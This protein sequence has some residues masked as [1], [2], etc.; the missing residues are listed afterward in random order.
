MYGM[1]VLICADQLGNLLK[2][3]LHVALRKFHKKSRWW[4]KAGDH[5]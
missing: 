1:D 5:F 3:T 2:H 4:F